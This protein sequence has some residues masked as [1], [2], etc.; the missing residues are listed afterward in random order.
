MKHK[1]NN[2]RT[3]LVDFAAQQ[4]AVLCDAQFVPS[5]PAACQLFI[6]FSPSGMYKTLQMVLTGW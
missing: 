2:V 6:R 5:S 1:E 4:V 3:K